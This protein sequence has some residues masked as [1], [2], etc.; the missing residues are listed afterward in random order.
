M[1]TEYLEIKHDC[2]WSGNC[3]R[4]CSDNYKMESLM[5][6]SPFSNDNLSDLYFNLYGNSMFNTNGQDSIDLLDTLDSDDFIVNDLLISTYPTTNTPTNVNMHSSNMNTIQPTIYYQSQQPIHQ[7]TNTTSNQQSQKINYINTNTSPAQPINVTMTNQTSG[8]ANQAV[9]SNSNFSSCNVS[10]T[11][12]NLN[13]SNYSSAQSSSSS[14]LSSSLNNEKSTCYINDLLLS[15]TS[16]NIMIT[17]HN[18]PVVNSQ[19][20]SNHHQL[21]NY[22]PNCLDNFDNLNNLD[23]LPVNTSSSCSAAGLTAVVNSN[24]V[25]AQC[26]TQLVNQNHYANNYQQILNQNHNSMNYHLMDS[27]FDSAGSSSNSECSS[28]VL[29]ERTDYDTDDIEDDLDLL[30][31]IIEEECDD[32]FSS[33]QT[34]LQANGYNHQRAVCRSIANSLESSSDVEMSI[35]SPISDSLINDHSYGASSVDN[36]PSSFDKLTTTPYIVNRSYNSNNNSNSVTINNRNSSN[37]IHHVNSNSNRITKRRQFASINNNNN[38]QN[39]TNSN[40]RSLQRHS[41]GTSLLMKEKQSKMKKVMDTDRRK[42]HNESERMR[43]DVLK[44]AFSQLRSRCPKLSS[45]TKKSSRIQ[46][47][48][49]ATIYIKQINEKFGHLKELREQEKQRQEELKAKLL[50]LGGA[51]L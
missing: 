23:L 27:A 20:N 2:M 16:A 21:T 34:N 17:Q 1:E 6:K 5:S 50:S 19:M 38:N 10:S 24:D 15:S 7:Q 28:S 4:K 32:L 18:Q 14:L 43:R 35:S 33:H 22:T 42:E 49:E 36:K 44:N 30:E 13:N 48:N 51:N 46:I 11:T 31:D 8:T 12:S 37:L 25:H 47:L 9:K 39:N 40:K 26:N 45:A 3:D 29:L 41:T